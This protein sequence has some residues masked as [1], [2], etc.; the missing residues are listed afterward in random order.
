MNSQLRDRYFMSLA[1][2]EALRA[3]MDDEAPVGAV[4]VLA[5][6][7][8]ARAGNRKE[9]RRDATAHAEMEVL[10]SASRAVGDWR[11]T[12]VTLYVTLE[13][14]IMCAG[15]MLQ[16]RLG[17]LVYGCDDPKAGGIRSLYRLAEDERLNHRIAVTAGV[18]A[19]PS[20]HL[21]QTFF[22]QLRRLRQGRAGQ[23]GEPT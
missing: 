3:F 1:F 15:A 2:D 23:E 16:A 11:L 19:A 10:R 21:L 4:A 14:C 7:V 12:A 20:R 17:R 18:L 6:R 22:R 5:G 9:D 13:P 8:I